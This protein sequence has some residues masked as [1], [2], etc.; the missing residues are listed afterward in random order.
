MLGDFWWP[1]VLPL[2]SLP[3]QSSSPSLAPTASLPTACHAPVAHL[4]TAWT[5]R[6][7]RRRMSRARVTPFQMA[8]GFATGVAAFGAAIYAPLPNA[9]AGEEHCFSGVR[10]ACAN[11][12]R[13]S[14]RAAALVVAAH[15]LSARTRSSPLLRRTRSCARGTSVTATRSLGCRPRRCRRWSDRRPQVGPPPRERNSKQISLGVSSLCACKKI[16][17]S[18]SRRRCACSLAA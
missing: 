4:R 14:H 12:R 2:L 7:C 1:L 15:S 18:S 11:S 3:P 6:I 9:A 10:C 16:T 13:H 5:A 8:T 17:G